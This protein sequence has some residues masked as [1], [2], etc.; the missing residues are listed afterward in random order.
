M[1][2]SQET[3]MKLATLIFHCKSEIF[4]YICKL[5]AVEVLEDLSQAYVHTRLVTY[6]PLG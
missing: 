5:I 2:M 3:L 6:Y 1:R 4:F